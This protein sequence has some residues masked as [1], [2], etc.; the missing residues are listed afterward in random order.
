MNCY[1]S[2]NFSIFQ[3]QKT[4]LLAWC[5]A[6][7][8]DYEPAEE[9]LTR[10][11]QASLR[12]LFPHFTPEKQVSRHKL[13]LW[14]LLQ[15]TAKKNVINTTLTYL[16]FTAYKQGDRTLNILMGWQKGWNRNQLNWSQ[17]CPSGPSLQMLFWYLPFIWKLTLGWLNIHS[18]TGMGNCFTTD[19]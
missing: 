7:F 3:Q 8:Q 19:K 12:E 5:T 1:F 11:V 17:P 18:F 14:V 15:F 4:G 9:K 16:Y 2:E 10:C 13:S 6:I